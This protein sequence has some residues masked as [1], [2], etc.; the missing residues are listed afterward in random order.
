MLF[1]ISL[2][3]TTISQICNECGRL[4]SLLRGECSYFEQGG[5]EKLVTGGN[6]RWL[7]LGG[8]KCT[9]FVVVAIGGA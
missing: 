4:L 8:S 3:K 9:I 2:R 7:L 5:A 6:K 1:F